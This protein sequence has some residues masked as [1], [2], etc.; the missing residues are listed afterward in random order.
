MDTQ[1]LLV[2]VSGRKLARWDCG[3]LSVFLQ[4]D[5]GK[6]PE[7]EC[8][9]SII[10]IPCLLPDEN[11]INTDKGNTSAMPIP[12]LKKADEEKPEGNWQ[13][14]EKCRKKVQT[15]A[16]SKCHQELV[17]EESCYLQQSAFLKRIT[18]STFTS[19]TSPLSSG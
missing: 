19:V 16:Q 18:S 10:V 15:S 2:I 5:S 6:R 7:K 8:Q 13:V 11:T 3:K 14:V 12:P 17:R 4:F 9:L 1:K